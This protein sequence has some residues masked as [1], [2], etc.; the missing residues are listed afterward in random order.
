MVNN[1][2]RFIKNSLAVSIGFWGLQSCINATKINTNSSVKNFYGPLLDDPNGILKLPKDFSYTIISKVGEKMSDGLFTPGK[3]DGMA[4]FVNADNKVV[5]VR[6]HEISFGDT[7]NSAFGQN[8]ELLSKVDKSNFYDFGNGNYP[9][10]GG[11][12]TLL[13]NTATKKIE[14][15]YMS[16]VGTIRNC[17]GGPTPWN[18]WLTCEED[19]SIA[20]NT[21]EKNHG[22]VFEVPSVTDGKVAAPLP[23]KEMGRFNHEAVAID[24]NTGIVYLTEDRSDGLFY[25]Y[26]PKNAKNLHKGGQLQI[27]KFIDQDAT[28]TRNWNSFGKQNIET[29]KPYNV[30]WVNIDDV[31]APEDDLRY[32]G[33]HT[34]K[35]AVF[36]RGEGIWYGNKGVYFAC[37]NGGSAKVGQIFKYEPSPNEGQNTEKDNPATITLF[38]EPND[39]SIMNN[40]DNLTIAPW[41]DVITAEDTEHPFLVGIRPNGELY[42]LAENIGYASEFAGVCFSPDGNTLFVNIQHAGLTIAINGPWK[43]A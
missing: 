22:Y 12:T 30:S 35:A 20:N 14:Q 8:N 39:S 5:I 34:Q 2:R 29:G 43:N 21:I 37:T 18:T 13:Y 1:R 19:V 11:T 24:P 17:A 16:L 23:I 7:A 4:T 31:D 9:G 36:A 26:L 15:S 41:G 33:Y 6:N 3:P 38:V 40:A 28:D 27:L 42:K 32:R 10:L 25:R